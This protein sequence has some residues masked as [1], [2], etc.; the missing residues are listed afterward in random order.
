MQVQRLGALADHIVIEAIIFIGKLPW[1]LSWPTSLRCD[2]NST[3]IVR[4]KVPEHC[5][6]ITEIK[7]MAVED[8][9]EL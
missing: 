2:G 3:R 5:V 6:N 9:I 1:R 4:A 8:L 7:T